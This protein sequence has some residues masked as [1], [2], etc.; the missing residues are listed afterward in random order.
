MASLCAKKPSRGS[1]LQKYYQLVAS[2]GVII[3]IIWEDF[4]HH[5]AFNMK[6][7]WFCEIAHSGNNIQMSQLAQKCE[8]LSNVIDW[9][10]VSDCKQ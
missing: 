8:T 5:Y 9:F 7:V 6:K 10:T 2:I 3:L 1:R 4:I